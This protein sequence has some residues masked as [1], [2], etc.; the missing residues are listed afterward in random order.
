MTFKQETWKTGVKTTGQEYH[1]VQN[2]AMLHLS[3]NTR[4]SQRNRYPAN[5][6]NSRLN[7]KVVMSLPAPNAQYTLSC[8][9]NW[10]NEAPFL[11]GKPNVRLHNNLFQKWE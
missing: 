3:S 9:K 6:R 5:T 2:I 1:C 10:L 8:T 7:V 4:K 11:I